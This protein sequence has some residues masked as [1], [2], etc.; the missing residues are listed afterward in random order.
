MAFNSDDDEALRRYQQRTHQP[1]YAPGM[2]DS[3]LDWGMPERTI[4]GPQ[5]APYASSSLGQPGGMSFAH[6]GQDQTASA[7]STAER[8]AMAAGQ[9]S[10]QFTKEAVKAS[11]DH[12]ADTVAETGLSAL[13][14]SAGTCVAGTLLTLLSIF[15]PVLSFG[16]HVLLGGM[17]SAMCGALL[18]TGGFSLSTLRA[19]KNRPAPEPVAETPAPLPQPAPVEPAFSSEP[20]VEAV[21]TVEAEEEDLGWGDLLP[22]QPVSTGIPREADVPEGMK[23]MYTRGFLF[24]KFSAILPRINP[25]I[26]AW[27]TYQKDTSQWAVFAEMIYGAAKQINTPE[28]SMPELLSAQ[29]NQ[30]MYVFTVSRGSRLS[31]DKLAEELADIYRYDERGVEEHPNARA[32]GFKSG[33][34]AFIHLYKGDGGIML[35]TGDLYQDKGVRDFILNPQNKLPVVI[36]VDSM[37]KPQYGSLYGLNSILVAGPTRSGKSVFAKNLVCQMSAYAPPTEIQFAICDAKGEASDYASLNLPHIRRKAFTASDILETL[38]FIANVEVPRRSKMFAES[39]QVNILDFKKLNPDVELPF[40]YMLFDELSTISDGMGSDLSEYEALFKKV[41][42]TFAS[43]GIYIIVTPQRAVNSHLPADAIKQIRAAAVLRTNVAEDVVR[44]LGIRTASEFPYALSHPGDMGAKFPFVQ[45]GAPTFI[46][47]AMLAADQSETTAI[48]GYISSY[49]EK[50]G[51]EPASNQPMTVP[52]FY[53]MADDDEE[54][55]DD[56]LVEETT[57]TTEEA[58]ISASD[59]EKLDSSSIWGLLQ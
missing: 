26:S 29:E 18:F 52:T 44:A 16:A 25:S 37:G 39:G 2:G 41:T 10:W 4:S 48:S 47:A 53:D 57:E 55:E 14:L 31:H 28:D 46:K 13:K 27:T 32:V 23:G 35:S 45:D 1:T 36:G 50:L 17:F 56:L 19:R 30:F 40:I 22:A 20:V 24:E 51:F 58:A 3:N 12:T 38:R 7:Q 15:V 34:K 9:A 49:W 5:L 21:P 11:K 6:I 59:A 43:L 33:S 54:E 8:A 42:N